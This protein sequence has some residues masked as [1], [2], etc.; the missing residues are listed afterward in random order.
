[1]EMLRRSE[2]PYHP[3]KYF[4]GEAEDV[5]AF[6][7]R[8]RT[9]D[10]DDLDL[11]PMVDVTFLLLIFFILTASLSLQ[12]AIAVP[13]PDPQQEGAQSTPISLEELEA[14]S[15]IVEI[16]A[17]NTIIVDDETLGPEG[18]LARMLEQ[19]MTSSGRREMVINAHA[20][21]F[22][23]TTVAVFDAAN[24]VGMQRIRMVTTSDDE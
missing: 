6:Q 24:E 1:M 19:S 14:D 12:K 18:D 5:P 3:E 8:R 2:K 16:Q 9:S 20:N 4:E 11:T 10:E 21:S 17:D 7:V 15:I 13:P 23:E 22:H